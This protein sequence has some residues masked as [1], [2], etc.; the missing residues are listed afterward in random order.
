MKKMRLINSLIFSIDLQIKGGYPF[1]K[2][3]QACES[4]NTSNIYPDFPYFIK[5]DHFSFY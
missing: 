4:N 5:T 2:A 1:D 3:W